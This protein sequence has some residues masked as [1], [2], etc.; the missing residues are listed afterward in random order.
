MPDIVD[1]CCILYKVCEITKENYLA[2]WNIDAAA[3]VFQAPQ[4][5][6]TTG[7]P[8]PEMKNMVTISSSFLGLMLNNGQKCV[9]AAHNDATEKLTFDLFIYKMPSHN[10]ILLH[11]CLKVC[12]N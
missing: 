7:P 5:H 9:F 12:N 6:S 2:K 11:I 8:G 4:T 1:A 10:F 3:E